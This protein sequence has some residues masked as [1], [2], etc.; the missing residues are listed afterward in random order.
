[1]MLGAKATRVRRTLRVARGRWRATM[2]L[3]GAGT[4]TLR[5]ER[6]ASR[7]ATPDGVQ[8]VSSR[9]ARGATPAEA[10]APNELDELPGSAR[11]DRGARP[12]HPQRCAL[13]ARLVASA[14]N[15][16]SVGFEL[17]ARR[18]QDERIAVAAKSA[19]SFLRSLLDATIAAASSWGIDARPRA[20][21][22][23]RL[24]WEWLASTATVVDGCPDVRL[25]AEC[26]R[27]LAETDASA[28]C[29]LGDAITARFRVATAEAYSLA[30]AI[31]QA[32]R[33]PAL[34]T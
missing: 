8:N 28:A 19:A 1:M 7:A 31:Q 33:A 18:T 24:R 13:G 17:C 10:G 9:G 34:A 14:C 26:A 4:P 3:S 20:Q 21:T 5:E 6:S 25:I 11:R 22:R 29:D 2:S 12:D 30:S 32:Q 27:I 16:A 15:A 23:E